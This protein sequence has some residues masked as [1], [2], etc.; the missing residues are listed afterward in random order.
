MR[1][2]LFMIAL[3]SIFMM[4]CSDQVDLPTDTQEETQASKS[5]LDR[6]SESNTLAN[7]INESIAS[8]SRTGESTYP[9]ISVVSI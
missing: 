5:Y 3:L 4:S 1:I 9:R 2:K 8:I 7:K 6:A